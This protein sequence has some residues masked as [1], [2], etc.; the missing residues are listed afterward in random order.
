[1]RTADREPNKAAEIAAAAEA[2][3]NLGDSP[4]TKPF[5]RVWGSSYF[6]KWAVIHD[7]FLRLG[8]PDGAAVL[9]VGCG[10]GWTTVFLAES[11]Y[12]P[13]GL[14]IAPASAKLGR[15]RAARWQVGADFQVG[16]MDA[17]D[18]GR[19]FDAVLLFD[20]LHH[21]ARQADV[22]ACVARH[23]RPGGW[24]L[25]GEPSWLHAI[26]PSAKRVNRQLGWIERG[27]TARSVRRDCRAAGLTEFRRFFEGTG[28]YESRGRGFLWQLVRLVAANVA[29]APR[30]SVWLA[31]RRTA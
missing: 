28:P 27:V 2:L 3:E 25:F 22:I 4:H 12:R 19:T 24:A 17:F 23:L 18:L 16:D 29:V 10:A 13:T 6:T 1:M 14:D 5:D 31:A 26:S 30:S 15:D 9:D 11:G 21:S 8:V 20:A 7:A